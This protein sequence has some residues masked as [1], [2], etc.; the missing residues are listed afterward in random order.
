MK[1]VS[2]DEICESITGGGV[3]APLAKELLDT[4]IA[5]AKKIKDSLFMISPFV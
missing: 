5:M 3:P 1:E 4:I 2:V